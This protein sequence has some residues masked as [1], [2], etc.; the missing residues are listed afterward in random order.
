PLR[1]GEARVGWRRARPAPHGIEPRLDQLLTEL[2]R[3]RVEL[4]R[5]PEA[6]A[7]LPFD[8]CEELVPHPGLGE[9]DE[10][11]PST[12][13]VELVTDRLEEFAD[14]LVAHAAHG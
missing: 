13:A 12:T 2:G 6:V 5:R 9:E 7:R 8:A 3:D 1:I 11:R 10:E 4:R 14:R